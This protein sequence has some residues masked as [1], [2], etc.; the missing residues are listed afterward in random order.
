M[1]TALAP[2]NTKTDI[3]PWAVL[4]IVLVADRSEPSMKP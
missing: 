3:R 4:S 2:S 1:T